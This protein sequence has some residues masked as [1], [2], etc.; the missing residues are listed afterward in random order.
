MCVKWV[1]V[2]LKSLTV[3]IS[4]KNSSPFSGLSQ[5]FKPFFFF[6]C[7]LLSLPTLSSIWSLWT[8]RTFLISLLLNSPQTKSYKYPGDSSLL[9]KSSLHLF[10]KNNSDCFNAGW[11]MWLSCFKLPL[12]PVYITLANGSC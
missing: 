10:R 7:L 11:I 1:H 12:L 5:L 2:L 3:P 9:Q 4:T 8:H 6:F